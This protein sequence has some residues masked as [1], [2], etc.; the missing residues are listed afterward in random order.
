MHS[1][2]HSSGFTLRLDREVAELERRW[3]LP[4]GHP[5]RLDY[6]AL[7]QAVAPI[8]QAEQAA[9]DRLAWGLRR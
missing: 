6:V 5:E 9:M 7:V 2:R 1:E 3:D 8:F 4:E